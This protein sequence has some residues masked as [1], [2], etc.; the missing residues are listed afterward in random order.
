MNKYTC[1]LSFAAGCVVGAIAMKLW[2]DRKNQVTLEGSDKEVVLDK[3]HDILAEEKEAATGQDE[4]IEGEL[5]DE[6]DGQKHENYIKLVNK[7]KP[8]DAT[9][10]RENAPYVI[11]PMEW[12]DFED[13][14]GISLT[15]TA[16]GVL[17]DDQF[18]RVEDVDGTV[19]AD[20]AS[21]FGAY[22]DDPDTIYI[23]N[24]ALCSDFEICKDLRTEADFDK[25][26]AHMRWRD[27]E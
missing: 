14:A 10:E 1:V 7:Y 2:T 3:L 27:D 21:K 9:S 15:Y 8:L 26:K 25:E 19:G 12:G 24:D 13:Y 11:S 17:L 4:I 5:V 16:D 20:F 18:E 23:R 6:D 22:P